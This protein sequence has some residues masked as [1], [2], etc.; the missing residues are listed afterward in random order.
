MNECHQIY[1]RCRHRLTPTANVN[2]LFASTCI[3]GNHR[4]TPRRCLSPRLAYADSIIRFPR[5]SITPCPDGT[6]AL[7][8]S[9]SVGIRQS[10]VR[11]D[12]QVRWPSRSLQYRSFLFDPAVLTKS[13]AGNNSLW[14]LRPHDPTP[15]YRWL[16]KSVARCA[17]S[18]CRSG[19]TSCKE[20]SPGRS[21]STVTRMVKRPATTWVELRRSLFREYGRTHEITALRTTMSRLT[22]F[23]RRAACAAGSCFKRMHRLF[24][25]GGPPMLARTQ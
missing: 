7:L 4:R 21:A 1:P 16:T 23:T 8:H 6:A 9:P 19:A 18:I 22:A 11:R 25:D 10:G 15:R 14:S 20:W 2:G 24:H 5:K 17:M 3:A 12:S 13:P